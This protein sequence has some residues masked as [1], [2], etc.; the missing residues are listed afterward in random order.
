MRGTYPPFS[1][2]L[3]KCIYTKDTHTHIHTH[4]HMTTYSK[5]STIHTNSVTIQSSLTFREKNACINFNNNQLKNVG[6]PLQ[7][8]DAVNKQYVDA[9]LSSSSG[10]MAL[11]PAH[12]LLITSADQQNYI[13]TKDQNWNIIVTKNTA[14]I[15]SEMSIDDVTVSPGMR[16][17]FLI[18]SDC[19][20]QVYT[21]D[22]NVTDM[23]Y[24][25][26]PAG[27]VKGGECVLVTRGKFM[28]GS[29]WVYDYSKKT[30]TQIAKPRPIV[31]GNLKINSYHGDVNVG[32]VDEYCLDIESDVFIVGA[33]KYM[34]YPVPKNTVSGR[35]E[36]Q[37]AGY[38]TPLWEDLNS[39][40][41]YPVPIDLS[42]LENMLPGMITF[43]ALF[44]VV[45]VLCFNNSDSIM[46]SSD[47]TARAIDKSGLE[48]LNQ[49]DITGTVFGLPVSR[50][51]S[52]YFGRQMITI[53][54][55]DEGVISC[56]LYIQDAFGFTLRDGTTFSYKTRICCD[57]FNNP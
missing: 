46:S 44:K 28:A 11:E 33:T 1:S 53:N 19:P 29:S 4:T 47:F 22:K 18:S 38:D 36:I 54:Q 17:L 39:T 21:V 26:I 30:F 51:Q 3:R 23:Q 52:G 41:W 31:S 20:N 42:F 56:I 5:V 16:V 34:Y 35:Y 7:R 9:I 6:L 15:A 48:Q 37:S 12:L 55:N 40:I 45:L 49:S 10:F 43:H 2:S 27:Y 14:Y 32:D 25:L 24:K 8:Y 57:L 50:V 13:F